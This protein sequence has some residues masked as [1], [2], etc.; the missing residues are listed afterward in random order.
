MAQTIVVSSV[1]PARAR[2][3]RIAVSTLFFATGAL[4]ASYVP[5]LPEIRD[6]LALTNTELGTA[7]AALP[8]GGLVVGGFAGA[9]IARFGSRRVGVIAGIAA[10]LAIASIGLATSWAIL[11]PAAHGIAMSTWLVRLGLVVSPPLIGV[12]ADAVGL[13]V[14][15]LLP[16]A[17]AISI[18]VLA[19]ILT[20][21]PLGRRTT[22]TEAPVA[23]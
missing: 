10:A 20:A 3:A 14:A 9:V 8:I 1:D 5:R 4:V 2:S 7:I 12:T 16:L 11:I 22:L 13:Q 21:T 17:A 15:M 6:H 18:A 19:P 23:G